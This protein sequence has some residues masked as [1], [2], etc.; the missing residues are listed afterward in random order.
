[1]LARAV[2]ILEI[3]LDVLGIS[4]IMGEAVVK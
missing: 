1:V 3:A 2:I 4:E